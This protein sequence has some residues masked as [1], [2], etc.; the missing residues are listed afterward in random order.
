MHLYKVQTLVGMELPFMEI[1]FVS[2]SFVFTLH[3][4]TI[5]VLRNQSRE[6]LIGAYHMLYVRMSVCRA[7]LNHI[8][9]SAATWAEFTIQPPVRLYITLARKLGIF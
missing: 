8:V 6:L 3:R 5:I 9:T 2:V 4:T 7:I 1:H